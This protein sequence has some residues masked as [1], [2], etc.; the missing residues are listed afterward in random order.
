MPHFELIHLICAGVVAVAALLI[1]LHILFTMRDDS[2]RASLWIILVLCIPVLGIVLYLLAGITRRNTLGKRISH[3]VEEFLKSRNEAEHRSLK[4]YREAMERFICRA[5][6]AGN[7]M[8]HRRMLDALLHSSLEDPSSAPMIPGTTPLAGNRLELLCDGSAAYPAM[9]ECIRSARHNINMQTFIFA[10]DRIGR[11]MMGELKKKAQ[12]G[13]Q[14]RVICDRFGS[15]KSL[16]SLFFLP[17]LKKTPNLKMIPFSNAS[18]L[19]PW[20]IQL[21]NHRKLLIVDG[22]TAFI[23]GL[24]ISEE[25]FKWMTS[26]EKEIHDFHCRLTGPSVGELQYAFLCDW[27]YASHKKNKEDLFTRDY[28]PMPEKCGDSI[29]RAVASGHGY[30]FEGS[31]KAFFTAASTAEKSIWIISPY[32]APSKDFSKALRM[33]SARGVDVRLI[34]PRNN[35]HWYVKMAARSFYESLIGNGVRVFERL[36]TFTHAKA[37]LVDG[38]WAYFGSSNC[39]IRSFRLNYELDLLVSQ[40]DFAEALHRQFLE[41]LKNSEEMGEAYL[42]SRTRPQKLLESICALMTP[43]L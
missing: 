2:E 18:L 6:A 20:R 1:I 34:V 30:L 32:F 26:P 33:A 25:N 10:D 4:D 36:G 28:F 11:I 13:V 8:D 31:E 19:T 35:N 15:F 38:E 16:F 42:A 3:A 37:M 40:G 29:V 12:E 7:T 43:V 41:E 5:D 22:K 21:R 9:I 23:G 24:N 14:V 27:F 17:Y 39:D